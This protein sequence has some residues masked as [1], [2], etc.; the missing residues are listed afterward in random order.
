MNVIAHSAPNPAAPV[1][2]D[3]EEPMEV[4]NAKGMVNTASKAKWGHFKDHSSVRGLFA[5]TPHLP[6]APAYWRPLVLRL[7]LDVQRL[8]FLAPYL[9]LRL[10]SLHHLALLPPSPFALVDALCHM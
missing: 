6:L 10:R 8:A 5:L 3:K 1:V 9:L 7:H 2:L 4:N